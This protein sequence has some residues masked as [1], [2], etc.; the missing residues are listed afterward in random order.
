MK[1]PLPARDG[2]IR[3][4]S[5]LVALGMAAGLIAVFFWVPEDA[6]Q[7]QTQRIF[8]VHVPTAWVAYLAFGMVL[9]GSVAYLITRKRRWDS[10]ARAS[11]EVGVLF[12]GLNLLSGMLWGKPIWG[13]YWTWDARLTTTFVMFLIY[14]G[15]LLFRTL[16][17]DPARGAR[18]AAVIGIVGFV[19]VP[20]VHYSVDWWRGQHPLP[21]VNIGGS[22]QLPNSMLY[23]MLWMM[24][25]FTGLFVV[26][27]ALRMRL[28]DT[29][30]ALERAEEERAL[31]S[32]AP[33]VIASGGSR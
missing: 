8:Y 14:A 10:F 28:D 18:L 13:T 27:V 33:T 31:A 22:S 30:A 16:A 26:L 23:T 11:A 5:I 9:L 32:P 4:L 24:V 7:L 6:V 20:L 12:T 2:L 1:I 21:V 25:V 3:W 17:T 29:E 15:Y 19:D